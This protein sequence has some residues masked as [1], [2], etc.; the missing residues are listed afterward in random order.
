M[1]ETLQRWAQE[2]GY[3]VAW[4]PAEVANEVRAE[5]LGRR[6]SGELDEQFF[7]MEL[8]PIVSGAEADP[9]DT[10]I[11]V[12]KPC[13]A[14]EVS[15][16]LGQGRLEALL[17]PTYFRYRPTFEDLRQDLAANAL[18]GARLEILNA[19]LKAVAARLGLVR[20]GRNNVTYAP[21]M[22]SYLQLCG[23]LTDAPFPR[24]DR[25]GVQQ[26][27]PLA[28]CEGCDACA[29]ACPTGAVGAGRFLLHGERCLTFAN[30]ISGDWP[31]WVPARAHHCL[32][33]CLACQRACPANPKLPV[34]SS[35]VCFSAAETRVLLDGEE[36]G[37][38]RSEGRIGIRAKLAWLGQPYAESVLGRNLRALLERRSPAAAG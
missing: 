26:P 6:A 4:G 8:E 31:E 32:L 25:N 1:I 29:R 21:G 38:E 12:A 19:P 34:V 2:R 24:G 10:V 17:P 3:C 20:Y 7:Q 35:G 18:P 36:T 14:Q 33:G 22:G 23:F 5:V 9:G 27:Q 15:F 37:C 13:S 16:E 30:E 28:E 11:M